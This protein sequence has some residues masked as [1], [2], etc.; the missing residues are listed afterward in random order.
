MNKN[1]ETE[2]ANFLIK[3]RGE[4]WSLDLERKTILDIRKND[5]MHDTWRSMAGLEDQKIA[6]I[7]SLNL[8]TAASS[9]QKIQAG[10]RGETKTPVKVLK[11]NISGSTKFEE[12][13]MGVRKI[14][15]ALKENPL[16]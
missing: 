12:H 7:D 3:R 2:I 8:G 14:A 9:V 4:T 5:H 6:D 1:D 11:S 13:R 15:N 10:L 16:S